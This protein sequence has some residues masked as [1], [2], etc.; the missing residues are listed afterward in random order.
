MQEIAQA[1]NGEY[2]DGSNTKELVEQVQNIL[3][4]MDKKELDAK[5][6]SDFKDQFQW[7]LAG[8]LLFLVLDVLLLERKTKW[9][10]KLNLFNQQKTDS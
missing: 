9:I 4:G 10:Y 5:Q 6:F 7:F 3:A 2:L 8:A 1:A